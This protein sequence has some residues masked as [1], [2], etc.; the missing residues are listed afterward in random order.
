[1]GTQLGELMVLLAGLTSSCFNIA[2]MLTVFLITGRI[3]MNSYGYVTT[4]R[5]QAIFTKQGPYIQFNLCHRHLRPSLIPLHNENMLVDWK[6]RLYLLIT[7][8]Y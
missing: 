3:Y 7:S 6:S 5:L 4:H 1:M 8:R 2:I